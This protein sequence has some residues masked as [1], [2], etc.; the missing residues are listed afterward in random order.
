[1]GF[2]ISSAG[3]RQTILQLWILF[4][5]AAWRLLLVLEQGRDKSCYQKEQKKIQ[6]QKGMIVK[7]FMG[8]YH[9]LWEN[10]ML[11]W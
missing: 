11:Q 10:I 1:M 8:E 3:R 5:G 2:V 6:M 7:S 9:C 4:F